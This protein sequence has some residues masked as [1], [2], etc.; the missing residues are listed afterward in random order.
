[1]FA[2]F[3]TRTMPVTTNLVKY[4]LA[5]LC[6]WALPRV[7][8]GQ[9]SINPH[10]PLRP[11]APTDGGLIDLP[12]LRDP[13]LPSREE[14]RAF[15]SRLGPLW[16]VALN[17]PEVEL[18]RQASATF[19][20][21]FVQGAP[22][23]ENVPARLVKLLDNPQEDRTVVLAVAGA[24]IQFDHKPAAE[25]LLAWSNRQAGLDMI[26]EVDPVLARWDYKPA[27]AVWMQRLSD[28]V[29]APQ[30]AISAMR[31]LATVGETQAAD[32]LQNI[33]VD[34]SLS[35]ALRLEAAR[36][37]GQIIASDLVVTARSLSVGPTSDRLLAASILTSH[38]DA[39]AVALLKQLVRDTDPT[40]AS[41]A[42]ATLRRID[43]A[44]VVAFGKEMVT[45]DD[46]NVRMEYV[47]ALAS[48]G[49]EETVVILGTLLDDQSV[50]VRS[51][52]RQ[53]LIYF[54]GRPKLEPAV[55]R[56][57]TR[58][59]DAPSWRGVEQAAMLA[60]IFD[61]EDNADRLLQLLNYPRPEVRLAAASS[62]RIMAIPATLEDILRHAEKLT[63][64]VANLGTGDLELGRS[65]GRE[66][67]Q[68]FMAIGAMKYQ[69]ADP[70]LRMYIPKHYGLWVNARVAAIWALGKIYADQNHEGLAARFTRR[71]SDLTPMDPEDN[72]VRRMSAICLGRMKSDSGVKTLERFWKVSSKSEEVAESCR[73]AIMQITDEQLRPMDQ[74]VI[75]WNRWFLEPM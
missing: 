67:T 37:L 1:M 62:L 38:S 46:A 17:R 74:R 19:G 45:H 56:T 58:E 4:G 16:V 51:A 61:A 11:L 48:D 65:Y 9:P 14:R 32:L 7:V 41:S 8:L 70:L 30:R 31:A 10:Q 26:V 18:R 72:R 53:N 66:I 59:L 50:A 43:P 52:A 6:L 75:Q 20:K 5:C 15:D 57:V 3:K 68:L 54:N 29:L 12:M 60:G 44:R 40:V 69:P 13:L 64:S 63:A 34:S 25:Q 47:Q 28:H 71:L 36:A 33:A 55:Q 22:G 39:T 23:L 49:S 21:A 24:L 2:C 73:W 42:L 35:P 27:R